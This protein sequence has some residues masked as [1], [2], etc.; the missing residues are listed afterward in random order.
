MIFG[1]PSTTETISDENSI[2][3]TP[4]FSFFQN[5]WRSTRASLDVRLGGVLNINTSSA[6]NSGTAETDLISYTLF[7]NSLTTD[8][9]LIEIDAWGTYVSN[10]NNKTVALKFGSQ[11]LITTGAVAANGGS[12]HISAKIIRTAA[13]TQEILG[14]IIS[15]NSSVTDSNTRTAGTQDLATDLII[16]CIGTSGTAS[17]DITQYSLIVKL[18][19]YD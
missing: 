12:W 8:G 4:W 18:T 11:T 15:S 10:G 14:E 3:S 1:I 7:K 16:K 9:D 17:S 19:P 6:S 5:L 2:I 13:A